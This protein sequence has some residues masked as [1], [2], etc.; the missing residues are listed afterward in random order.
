MRALIMAI[1]GLLLFGAV[2]YYFQED[3]KTIGNYKVYYYATRCNPDELS[4][5]FSQL[6]LTP[7]VNKIIWMEQ[8]GPNLYKRMSWT[9]EYGTR[10]GTLV[11]K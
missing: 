6:T 8:I 11:R 7:C 9:P 3:T 2:W 4:S 1:I 5:S 10:E